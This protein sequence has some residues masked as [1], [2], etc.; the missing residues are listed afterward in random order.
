MQQNPNVASI[1]I[2][3]PDGMELT[4]INHGDEDLHWYTTTDGGYYI[5]QVLIFIL[6]PLMI[7]AI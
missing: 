4:V 3:Q 7:T 1:T 6:Q 2:P 5:I